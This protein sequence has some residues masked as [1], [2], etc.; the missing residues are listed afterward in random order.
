MMALQ[1]FLEMELIQLND[2]NSPV[3]IFHA[4]VYDMHQ[5]K[6]SNPMP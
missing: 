1:I 2:I 5:C 3:K 6:T 4:Q